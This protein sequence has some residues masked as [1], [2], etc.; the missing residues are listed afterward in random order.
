[1]KRL[2]VWLVQLPLLVWYVIRVIGN[3]RRALL[4]WLRNLYPELFHPKTWKDWWKPPPFPDWWFAISKNKDRPWYFVLKCP[5]IAHGIN[6]GLPFT[7]FR[8]VFPFLFEK[9]LGLGL[10]P[11]SVVHAAMASVVVVFAGQLQA[12]DKLMDETRIGYDARNVIW[13]T[14]IA[15]MYGGVVLLW[16]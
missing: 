3:Q 2:I 9:L 11:M 5:V 14:A 15:A 7:A 13:R 12:A 8:W 10:Q 1:M 4:E 16:A 6:F